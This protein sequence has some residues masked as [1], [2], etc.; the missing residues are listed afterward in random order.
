MSIR[1]NRTRR[2]IIPARAGF[3]CR[4]RAHRPHPGD[5]PRSRGVYDRRPGT[6]PQPRGSSPLARGLPALRA[7]VPARPGIIPARAGFTSPRTTITPATPD[8]PRSRG[9]Y[10]VKIS[11]CP[12]TAGSSPLARGLHLDA[13]RRPDDVRIIPA[14]AGFTRR[15]G[16]SAAR[17]WDHPRS[18]GVYL[19]MVVMVVSYLGSSPLARGLRARSAPGGRRPGIIPARAGFTL[20]GGGRVV[21]VGDHPRSRGVYRS[22]TRGPRSPSGSSPLARGLQR[23]SRPAGQRVRIIPARA[24][25][26]PSGR[27]PP[28]ARRDHPRSRGVYPR[29]PRRSPRSSGS[30]PLARGLPPACGRQVL[31]R[32]DHPRSRGVYLRRWLRGRRRRG[33]SPLARGLRGG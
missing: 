24:G 33:S 6:G 32:G 8:H 19:V 25:F 5:H 4:S 26:T 15:R 31:A 20:P 12:R 7:A 16:R 27:P 1:S 23:L 14:R 30:S 21:E 3:T 28:W 9:V 17:S 10:G 13:A 18:R 22:R 2:R 29:T 11:P